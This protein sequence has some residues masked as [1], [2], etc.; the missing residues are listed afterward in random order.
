MWDK[1][2][3]NPYCRQSFL[4]RS[5]SVTFSKNVVSPF[6]VMWGVCRMVENSYK[7][8]RFFSFYVHGGAWKKFRNG[9]TTCRKRGNRL[10][11]DC[12]SLYFLWLRYDSNVIQVMWNPQ[13]GCKWVLHLSYICNKID[14][15]TVLRY[16]SENSEYVLHFD[17]AGK[18]AWVQDFWWA[19]HF[20]SDF[21]LVHMG[22][23]SVR[24]RKVEGSTPFESISHRIVLY[25]AVFLFI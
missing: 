3:K 23:R 4:K 8:W 21:L 15:I 22:E 19:G 12:L 5:H 1:N 17:C 6:I 11:F 18:L 10:K 16:S 20:Q 2:I 14:C 25:D 9:R 13:N 24:I 7:G